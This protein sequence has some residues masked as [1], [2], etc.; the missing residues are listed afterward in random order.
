MS[1]L[2]PDPRE[3]RVQGDLNSLRNHFNE[4]GVREWSPEM[5]TQ[6]EELYRIA[7]E[8]DKDDPVDWVVTMNR[9]FPYSF[10][11]AGEKTRVGSILV[12]AQEFLKTKD[13]RFKGQKSLKREI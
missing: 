4:P 7:T 1:E 3:L 2:I 9:S 10:R 8:F 12:M 13:E 5:I 11:A 6:L